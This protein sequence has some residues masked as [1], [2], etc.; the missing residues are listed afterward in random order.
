[1]SQQCTVKPVISGNETDNFDDMVTELKSQSD[2]ELQKVFNPERFDQLNSRILYGVQETY[3]HEMIPICSSLIENDRIIGRY[4]DP[5][6]EEKEKTA[7]SLAFEIK[8]PNK[9]SSFELFKESSILAMHIEKLRKENEKAKNSLQI[10][11]L[12]QKGLDLDIAFRAVELRI[13]GSQAEREAKR[14]KSKEKI[15]I[16]NVIR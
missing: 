14:Q 15:K 13:A 4:P 9:L 3:K 5:K 16:W 11:T 2:T 12:A 6:Y 8:D 1:M 7:S 10:L